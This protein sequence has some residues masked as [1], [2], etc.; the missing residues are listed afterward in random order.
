MKPKTLM[1]LALALG[2]GLVASIGIS[3]VMEANSKRPAA[4]LET[5]PIFVALHNINLGDPIEASMV[6]LQEWPKD[7][8]PPGSVTLLENLEGRRPR[9]VIV[10][11][12]PI[13]D[14]QLLAQGEFADPIV[15]IPDGYR[16]STISV[17]A[18]K[19]A[20]G[21]LSPGD[22]VDIQLYVSANQRNGI[23]ETMT[24]LIL[25]NIRVFA[26]EQAVQRTAEGAESKNI[27]KTV[28]L[29]VTPEQASKLDLAQNLGE[30]SLIPRNPNDEGASKII[31][32]TA[33]DLLGTG[34]SKNTR[35]KEQ[36][37]DAA[38]GIDKKGGFLSSMVGLIRKAA[39]DRPPF[40]MEVVEADTVREVLF[41][42]ITGRAIRSDEDDQSP[43]LDRMPTQPSSFDAPG[44][45]GADTI[46][47]QGQE[48]DFPI[49][50]GDAG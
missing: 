28:S 19:S 18:E 16:L 36:N 32:I 7:R 39:D 46:K 44:T 1:L 2:C 9:T 20:A 8:I 37:R 40:S 25:Q 49:D 38:P 6:S 17:N 48:I 13:L 31:E 42:P 33:A 4:Q 22:R 30:L 24:R 47:T 5:T 45:S 50:F 43:R 12:M 34:S 15:N 29:L 10:A 27:P 11:G 41:D 23:A 26:V 14:A 3:Q 21:L 35:K